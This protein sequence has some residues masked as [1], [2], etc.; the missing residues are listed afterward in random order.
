MSLDPWVCR[1]SHT[2][3]RGDN[4]VIAPLGER[5]GW[6]MVGFPDRA[7]ATWASVLAGLIQAI[8]H[9]LA[10]YGSNPRVRKWTG[11]FNALVPIWWIGFPF[12]FGLRSIPAVLSVYLLSGVITFA[13]S[14][15]PGRAPWR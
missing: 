13:A 2:K 12:I 11:Q 15:E 1:S 9:V 14:L 6:A 8:L 7:L 4:D 10:T 3:R 5:P